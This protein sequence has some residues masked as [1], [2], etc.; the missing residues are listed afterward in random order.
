M[1]FRQS[2]VILLLSLYICC[3]DVI[4]AEEIFLQI[5]KRMDTLRCVLSILRRGKLAVTECNA[6]CNDA[7]Q[8][9]QYSEKAFHNGVSV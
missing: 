2:N 3:G 4:S 7:S 8:T 9:S 5:N 6:G 1:N